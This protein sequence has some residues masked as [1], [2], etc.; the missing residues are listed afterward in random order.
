MQ[1]LAKNLLSE[2]EALERQSR[3]NADTARKLKEAAL[4]LEA[5]AANGRTRVVEPQQ[6]NGTRGEQLMAYLKRVGAANRAT[7][8]KEAGIPN[9]SINGLLEKRKLFHKVE[10]KWTVRPGADDVIKREL[11]M[12]E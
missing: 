11:A 5:R 3:E 7:I 2:A 6:F 9:G 12:V 10:G 4:L 8:A 1:S